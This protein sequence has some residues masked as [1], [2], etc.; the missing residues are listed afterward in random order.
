MQYKRQKKVCKK[1]NRSISLSN[2]S[3]HTCN[4]KLGVSK[5]KNPNHNSIL[6]I[7]QRCSRSI[8][9][10]SYSKH[11]CITQGECEKILLF[12]NQGLCSREIIEKGFA[13]NL[14]SYALKGK[15]RSLSEA[16]KLSK[17]KGWKNYS[18]AEDFFERFLENNK[19]KLGIDYVREFQVSRYRIDF[20]FPKL[21][22]AIEIDGQ[23]HYKYKNRQISDKSKDNLLKSLDYKVLRI[24]FK[25]LFNNT[26]QILE[27]VLN[28]LKNTKEQ[29]VEIKNLT[30]VQ[31]KT[32]NLLD[33][34]NKRKELKKKQSEDKR[35]EEILNKLKIL[36]TIDMSKRGWLNEAKNKLKIS[37]TSIRRFLRI[38]FPDIEEQTYFKKR[39][40]NKKY[41]NL[42][43]E[44]YYRSRVVVETSCSSKAKTSVQ[45]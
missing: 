23:Q 24:S 15:F 28:I 4:S 39:T 26:K 12:Y 42:D 37:G 27:K 6:Q 10:Q 35:K 45:I 19:F 11:V 30:K 29:E 44:K 14:V 34:I 17:G 41:Q 13:S 20:F 22:L 18:Y 31:L 38:N 2:F 21:K 36:E 40:G 9:K 33:E 25:A 8:P 32:L 7:C 43:W 1:C 5:I 16:I 3:R